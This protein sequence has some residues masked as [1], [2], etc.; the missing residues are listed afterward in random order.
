M[1]GSGV[2]ILAWAGRCFDLAQAIVCGTNNGLV[3][4][5]CIFYDG[6]SQPGREK[7]QSIQIVVIGA[8][9]TGTPLLRQL[10][11]APFVQLRG[12]ADL[13]LNQPGI[14]LAREHG[15]Y[16]TTNFMELVDHTVDIVIDVSGSQQVREVLRSNMVDTDNT[17]TLIVHEAI[18]LLMMSLSAGRLVRSK[19]G[20]LEYM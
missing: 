16:V 18:A 15:V 2:Y 10:L 14:A 12:V 3:R 19:H 9:E 20:T 8:G 5:P 17:H 11:N 13:D 4:G 1:W 6:I 7:M